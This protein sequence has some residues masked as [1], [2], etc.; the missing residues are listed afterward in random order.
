ME[1]SL[2]NIDNMLLE[3]L[4]FLK[5]DC[6]KFFHLLQNLGLLPKVKKCDKC[7]SELYLIS[8][9]NKND[10]CIFFCS[11]CK[12]KCSIRNG[13]FFEGSHLS[14]WQ[15]FALMYFN[16]N[17]IN[18]SN[19]AICKQ[20]RIGSEHT[21]VDWMQY[22]REIY[23]EYLDNHREKI[24]SPGLV[25]QIDE[26]FICRRKYHRGRILVNQS[27]WI[28]GGIDNNGNIFQQITHVRDK[29]TL[30]NII[31][32]NVE[33]GSMIWTD[34]W[35]GY[36]DL[37]LIGYQHEVVIH[38]NGFKRLDGVHTNRIEAIWG[39]VKRKYRHITNK[40]SELMGYYLS[41]YDFKRK[42][43]TDTFKIYILTVNELYL[44]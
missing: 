24:G 15:V 32:N 33:L 2:D 35:K 38:K 21:V 41:Q 7:L 34:G 31:L 6:V 40:R 26:S 43:S 8:Q 28:V 44:H 19:K 22:I 4:F 3:D 10:L 36:K 1:F 30:E 9:K 11:F 18:M 12:K 27:C 29:P 13:T 25:V 37:S 17:D 23:S 5:N 14:L 16:I 39:A 42:F 20:L